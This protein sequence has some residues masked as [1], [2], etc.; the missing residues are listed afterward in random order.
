M[1]PIA[2]DQNY[3]RYPLN[4]LLG[5]RANVRLLRLLAEEVSGPISVSEAAEQTG[6]TV[7]GA[8]RAL[9][10][11]AR[12]GYVEQLGGG[13]SQQFQL[14]NADA[15]SAQLRA[16]FRTERDRYQSL[17]NRLRE[18]FGSFIEIQVAWIDDLPAEVGQPLHVG[19]LA[20]SRALAYLSDQIRQRLIGI[21]EDYDI[22]I[23]IHL[24]SR[25]DVPDVAW[26]R[27]TLLAGHVNDREGEIR[28]RSRH[29]DR[30]ERARKVSEAIAEMLDRDSSLKR[31]AERHL[32][33]LLDRDEGAASHD[34]R[35]WRDILAHYSHQ[36]IKDFLVSET[37]RAQ[38]LRQ[39]SPFFAVL[40]ADEREEL[41]DTVEGKHDI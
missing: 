39:S 30:I 25:A 29:S 38:R 12:T 23:E 14:R 21:E 16:L 41:L 8:R 9:Q 19:V 22:T 35:E 10:S 17:V 20:V 37:P 34:L 1:R 13:R 3:V 36:R 31:R 28:S 6:L 40:T 7:A 15:L 26:S 4:D 24:F 2:T 11:L 33:M 5:T 27:T 32:D 18:L